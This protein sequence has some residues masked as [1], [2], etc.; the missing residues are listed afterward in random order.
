MYSTNK[1]EAHLRC[2][3]SGPQ[4]AINRSRF[5]HFCTQNSRMRIQAKTGRPFSFYLLLNC[6][7]GVAGVR[8]WRLTSAPLAFSLTGLVP[9]PPSADQSTAN[10]SPVA[11]PETAP[12]SRPFPPRPPASRAGAICSIAATAPAPLPR[13]C[14][15]SSRWPAQTLVTRFSLFVDSGDLPQLFNVNQ[16][17]RTPRRYY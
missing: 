17:L 7:S 10:L 11:P 9:V 8:R 6:F 16:V 13:R 2:S 4:S 1:L 12:P 3:C 5:R 15:G 14:T